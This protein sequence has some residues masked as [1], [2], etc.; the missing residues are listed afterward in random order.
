MSVKIIFEAHATTFDNEAGL[1]SGWN[2]V[3]LSPLGLQQADDLGQRYKNQT[4]DAVFCSDL[5]RSY[6]TAQIAFTNR[7]DIQII[8]DK[9]LRECNY[10]TLTKHP[11]IEIEKQKVSKIQTPFPNGESYTDT[12]ARIKKFLEDLLKKYNH[13]S[14]LIIG[15]RATHYGI[16]HLIKGIP[17]TL[18][19]SEKFNWQP[20]WKYEL[21]K[22]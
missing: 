19:V 17:L 9:R 21:H 12:T 20:G 15:H 14:I 8:K 10:G 13:K 5:Q 18:L 16:E 3:E 2:D 6:K 11:S 22:Q 7:N 4:F 1:S